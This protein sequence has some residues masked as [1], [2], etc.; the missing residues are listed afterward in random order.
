[1]DQ[2]DLGTQTN[3]LHLILLLLLHGMSLLKRFNS[4]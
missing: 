2:P 3:A 4:H 1:M